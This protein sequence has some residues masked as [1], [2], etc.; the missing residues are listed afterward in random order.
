[1]ALNRPVVSTWVGGVP[2]LVQP[3]VNGWLVPAGSVEALAEAM[4]EVLE[5]QPGDLERMGRAGAARVARYHD[6][7]VEAGRLADLIVQGVTLHDDKQIRKAES[8]TW[9]SF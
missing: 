2:E 1:M 5:R 7:S 8:I 6:A 3:G 4:R 9:W